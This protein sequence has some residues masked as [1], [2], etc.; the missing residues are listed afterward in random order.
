MLTLLNVSFCRMFSLSA[1]DGLMILA[2]TAN[3]LPAFGRWQMLISDRD[4]IAA[5][6]KT[7]YF[8]LLPN[9]LCHFYD[10][11]PVCSSNATSRMSAKNLKKEEEDIWV[12][13]ILWKY[14]EEPKTETAQGG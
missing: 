10:I 12:D 1:K 9:R 8:T 14:E 4:C 5:C 2:T 11:Y 7:T 13:K 6:P 3:N